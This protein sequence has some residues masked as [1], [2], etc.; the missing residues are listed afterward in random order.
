MKKNILILCS[1]LLTTAALAQNKNFLDQGYLET[2]AQ[3]DTLVVPDRIYLGIVLQESDSKGRVSLEELEQK[4]AAR[5][6]AI[7]IDLEKQLA[8]SDLSSDFRKYFLRGQ[9]VLKDKAF[10]L[11]VYDAAMAGRVLFELEKLGIA[12]V[13]LNRTEYAGMDALQMQLK[14]RAMRKAKEQAVTMTTAIGQGL[15]KAIYI[16]DSGSYYPMAGTPRMLGYAKV[17]ADEAAYE[18]I[19]GEFQKIRVEASVQVKFL[20][21]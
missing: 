18:P 21:D 13:G 3:A 4:M 12:N 8:V 2:S 11:L 6:K 9:E 5:L 10:E 15:G 20:L 19:E 17:A 1:L 16:S 14:A 7:G